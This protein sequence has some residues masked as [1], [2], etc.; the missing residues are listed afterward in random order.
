MIAKPIVKDKYWIVENNGEKVATIQAVEKGGFVYVHDTEREPFTSI[1][2][3]IKKYSIKFATSK[4]KTPKEDTHH[5]YGYPCNSKPHN[6]VWDVQ[7]K[8]AVYSKT[9]KSRSLYCAGHYTI[10]F[11]G[12]WTT[13]FCPKL[14]TISRYE[15]MGPFRTAAEAAHQSTL[16]S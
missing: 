7:R 12:E 13:E 16:L 6:Q 5:C 8:L 11:D 4:D 10:R 15:F 2:S 14:I 3:L 9:A 1:K